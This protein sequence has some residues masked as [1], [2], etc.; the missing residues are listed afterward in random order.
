MSRIVEDLLLLANYG[1]PDFLTPEEVDV[2]T[3]T[4]EVYA[5]AKA[6]AP[7]EWVLEQRGYGR[8]TADRQRLTQAIV[9]LAQNAARH[10]KGNGPIAL[11]SRIVDGEARF[12]VSDR[13]PGIRLGDQAAIFERFRR[14]TGSSRL[15]GAGLGLS[16]VK[17]IAEAHGGRVEL[18]SRFGHGSTFAIVIPAGAAG[19]SPERTR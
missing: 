13:G 15:N 18:E 4:D 6:L 7:R 3:F 11:G 8:I 12:W 14:G 5:K 2:E 9:Q 19:A 10:S 17:A 1:R 16:I